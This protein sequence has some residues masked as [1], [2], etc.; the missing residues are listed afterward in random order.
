MKK[1]TALI[2]SLVLILSLSVPALAAEV[3]GV[4]KGDQS[5]EVKGK[6]VDSTT[7]PVVYSVDITWGS[8]EF[9]YA[10][11]GTKTWDPATHTY[12]TNTSSAWGPATEGADTFTITNH[13]N[14]TIY[15][16]FRYSA[17]TGFQSVNGGV[18]FNDYNI[19]SYGTNFESAE[20]TAPEN[21]P[22]KT[23][24][25]KLSGTPE[26]LDTEAVAVGT[27]TVTIS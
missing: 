24:T 5:A 12:T 16:E 21:A 1:L 11:S 8:M 19:S 7:K 13:S 9:V 27:V 22:S 25:F 26:S 10:E 2:L 20:G 3:E 15:C 23:F 14:G 18:Y 17:K 4:G 6:Y